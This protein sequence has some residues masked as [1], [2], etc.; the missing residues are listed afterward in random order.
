MYRNVQ[1]VVCG[2]ICIREL[3]GHAIARDTMKRIIPIGRINAILTQESC[4]LITLAV[5]N[6]NVIEIV[7]CLYIIRQDRW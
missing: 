7:R 6:L 4:K 1:C 3:A 5:L 2:I